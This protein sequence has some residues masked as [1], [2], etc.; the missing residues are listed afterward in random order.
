[1]ELKEF[2]KQ[3]D[4]AFSGHVQFAKAANF[5]EMIRSVDNGDFR[6]QKVG[7]V[8]DT[9]EFNVIEFS[10]PSSN[11]AVGTIEPFLDTFLKEG[12]AERID[13]VHGAG[14]DPPARQPA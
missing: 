9:N 11:L 12:G 3:L 13:Y 5:E 4:S 1:M 8:L 7:L 2:R 14:C 6:I 10:R